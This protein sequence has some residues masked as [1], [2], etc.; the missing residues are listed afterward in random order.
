MSPIVLLLLTRLMS[1]MVMRNIR[2]VRVHLV[3]SIVVDG[4]RVLC[5]IGRN[6]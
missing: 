2:L 5:R 4:R 6:L 1:A 3:R